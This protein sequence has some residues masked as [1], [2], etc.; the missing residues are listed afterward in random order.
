MRLYVLMFKY[1][2]TQITIK[3]EPLKQNRHASLCADVSLFHKK[4][5]TIKTEMRLYVLMLYYY[6]VDSISRLLQV[7]GLFCKRALQKRLY[8][9]EETYH[10]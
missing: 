2:K 8:S 6:G 1:Y 7:I 9:A 4:K 3:T 10:F 5:N